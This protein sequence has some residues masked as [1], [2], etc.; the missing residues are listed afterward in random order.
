[1]Q[2]IIILFGLFL[3]AWTLSD[4]F[5]TMI[6]PRTIARRTRL[7]RLFYQ[8]VSKIE[9]FAL[10]L[11]PS[12]SVRDMILNSYAPLSLLGLLVFWAFC[13]MLSFACLLWGLHIPLSGNA[14][15]PSFATYFYFSGVTFLTLGFGDITALQGIGRF[16]AI[17][18]AGTG[19]GF[20]A[21]VISYLPIL[22]QCFSKREV[23]ICKLDARAGSPPTVAEILRRYA[24]CGNMEELTELLREF[25]Q[26]SAELLESYLS[27][28]ILAFYRSQ[29]DQQS[30]LSAITAILD[31]CAVGR[32]RFADEREWQ[33]RLN[34]QAYLTFAMARHALIDLALIL[35]LEPEP[36]PQ[37]R[38]PAETWREMAQAMEQW[39]APL[40][41]TAEETERQLTAMRKLYEPYAYA[42]S[43]RLFLE[44]PP[45]KMQGSVADNW[46]ASAWEKD[47]HL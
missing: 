35:Y 13:L 39:G 36:P 18:E 6:L 38:L 12:Q 15:F 14:L 27:Y 9:Y 46:Q 21:I 43:K 40:I 4:A 33:K 17:C 11:S 37:D 10:R 47:V 7:T 25:E 32:L 24:E 22:Y 34:W 41:G 23:V 2:I 29:H 8:L 42:L 20:L 31:L 30:W 44:L 26:W 5:E 28:P 3:M 16:L 19:F 1:M 45:W